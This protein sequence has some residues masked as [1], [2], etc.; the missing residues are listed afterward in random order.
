MGV[1]LLGLVVFGTTVA[2]GL[3]QYEPALAVFAAYPGPMGD[4][5]TVG[6]LMSIGLVALVNGALVLGVG[7][8][9]LW[10]WSRH[11]AGRARESRE[12]TLGGMRMYRWPGV[13]GLV[14][15]GWTV[16]LGLDYYSQ[17]GALGGYLTGALVNGAIVYAV[18]SLVLLGWRKARGR[19]LSDPP[20]RPWID[21]DKDRAGW[22]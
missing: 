15:F 12:R 2:M 4:Y 22:R 3:D 14:V 19:P 13:L 11:R 17:P 6:I 18:A 20:R 1:V 21:R 8:V 5:A 7:V 9:V 10:A 16:A